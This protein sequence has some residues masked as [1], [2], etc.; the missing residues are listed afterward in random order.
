MLKNYME[1]VVD[2]VILDILNK[3]NNACKCELC[4]EDIKAIALNNLKPMYIVT[5]KGSI[6]ARV[7]EL[8]SQFVTD[9][10]KELVKA[11]EIVSKNP[12]HSL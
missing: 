9:T 4:V 2:H 5:E 6:Y 12:R 3:S 10:V 7:N 1:D 8:K 11:V